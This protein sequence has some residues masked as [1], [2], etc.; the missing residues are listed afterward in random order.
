MRTHS[1]TSVSTSLY[2]LNPFA[3]SVLSLRSLYRQIINRNAK[4]LYHAVMLCVFV[5]M[6]SGVPS[7]GL[8][9]LDSLYPKDR[10][11]HR[12]TP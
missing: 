8:D 3:L 1:F 6:K 11:T 12:H 7:T 2:I 4:G 10:I 5:R 9:I